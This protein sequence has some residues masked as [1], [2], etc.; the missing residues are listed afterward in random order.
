MNGCNR[1]VTLKTPSVGTGAAPLPAGKIL[2]EL[3]A[4][5]TGKPATSIVAEANGLRPTSQTSRP[6]WGAFCSFRLHSHDPT[7][8]WAI[9]SI[10]HL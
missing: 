9:S 5:V 8:G 2:D 7:S 4:F 3:R 6:R 10:A 1:S